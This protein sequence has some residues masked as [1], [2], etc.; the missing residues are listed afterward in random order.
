MLPISPSKNVWFYYQRLRCKSR[1]LQQRLHI[2]CV[3]PLLSSE[4]AHDIVKIH[5]LPIKTS[6]AGGAKLLPQYSFF[7]VSVGADVWAPLGR[8]SVCA[9]HADEP[10]VLGDV[11]ERK[12]DR[13]RIPCH[14]ALYLGH[15]DLSSCD[16]IIDPNVKFPVIERI[17]FRTFAIALGNEEVELRVHCEGREN[18]TE[19][20]L[21]NETIIMSPPVFVF[22]LPTFCQA[23]SSTFMI[24]AEETFTSNRVIREDNLFIDF[25][26]INDSFLY[27]KKDEFDR[28]AEELNT[29]GLS[30]KLEPLLPTNVKIDEAISKIR[31]EL[32]ARPRIR[33]ELNFNLTMGLGGI[34]LVLIM[35]VGGFLAIKHVPCLR[36]ESAEM[37][38]ASEG[39]ARTVRMTNHSAADDVDVGK[40]NNAVL[41]ILGIQRGTTRQETIPTA[42]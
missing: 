5:S 19:G 17:A 40:M 28:L 4:P 36:L 20:G 16:T 34:M 41:S 37:K 7:A 15:H 42:V 13:V 27:E 11:P 18:G 3:I 22:A 39:A 38:E 35:I 26:I 14:I 1:L 25:K 31:A 10:C 32:V 24:N 33:P 23:E 21:H 9:M 8:D 30:R 12:T 6:T 29:R 2:A